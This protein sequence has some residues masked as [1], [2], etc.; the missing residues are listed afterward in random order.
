MA[1]TSNAYKRSYGDRAKTQSNS[2]ARALLETMERKNTNLCVSVDTVKAA[3][4]LAIVDAVGPY[5]CL[6]KANI[7]PYYHQYHSFDFDFIALKDPYRYPRRFPVV[8]HRAFGGPREE[9]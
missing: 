7:L 4:F 6:V 2:A 9:A 8:H 3:D 5:I 1:S